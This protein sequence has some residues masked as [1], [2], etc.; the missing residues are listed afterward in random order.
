VKKLILIGLVVLFSVFHW[1]AAA[2]DIIQASVNKNRVPLNETAVLT[3]TL[4]GSNLSE[5]SLPD[6][7]GLVAY[8]AGQSQNISIINGQMATSSSFSYILQPKS[9][10][11]FTIGPIQVK[12][13]N[14]IHQTEAIQIEVTKA[15]AIETKVQSQS[16][17]EP[18][19]TRASVNSE[20]ELK[21]SV[22]A[23]TQTDKLA[24]Y[25]GEQVTFSYKFYRKVN[26]LNQPRYQPPS[27]T[28][29]WV[30]DLPPEKLYYEMI[31]GQKYVVSEIDVALFPT[32][33]GKQ[34]VG[35]TQLDCRVAMP[36]SRRDPFAVFDE[37]PFEFFSKD[38]FDA[39]S[40]RDLRVTTAPIYITVREL[41]LKNRPDDFNNAVGQ[42]KIAAALDKSSI[43][44]YQP[45]TLSI[46][47]SGTGNIQTIKEPVFSISNDFKIYD[48]GSS[49]DI[50]KTN[51]V[52]SGRKVFKKLLIPTKSGQMSI[53]GIR[54]SYF[55][56]KK[57]DYQ[58]ISTAPLKL[59]V[60]PGKKGDTGNISSEQQNK[61]E[62]LQAVEDIRFIK[63]Y[64]PALENKGKRPSRRTLWL[65]LFFPGIL[66]L[67]SSYSRL[68]SNLKAKNPDLFVS[69][70]SLNSSLK[71]LKQLHAKVHILSPQ[72]SYAQLHEVLMAFF[73]QKMGSTVRGLQ[74]RELTDILKK[75]SLA[76]EIIQEI[77]AFRDQA[78]Y[79][80][81]APSQV[82]VEDV[83]KE[84]MRIQML[85]T[86]IDR[87]L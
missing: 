10:G 84:I 71:K 14:D 5:P 35:S 23:K 46:E 40:G 70:S 25:T 2:D 37:D 12:Q 68:R 29:F 51:G 33:A 74:L 20:E 47:I 58:M 79:A 8:P 1:N 11:T 73:S 4:T 65:S 60:E 26:L 80:R 55:D 76:E 54:F 15:G 62:L 39:F 18:L 9:V 56:P 63:T 81:F 64:T 75:Q 77:N 72:Q 21:N 31:N 49:K 83:K 82:S 28:N 57:N 52:L 13:G 67:S 45:V 6:M 85:L 44:T 27:F 36:G 7:K 3:V 43:S 22:F 17:S 86:K 16:S 78:D 34:T 38:P 24:A 61:N 32:T 59:Q 69:K 50:Q 30:E 41:P 53:P 66:L 19:Q 87:I 42:F 48:S